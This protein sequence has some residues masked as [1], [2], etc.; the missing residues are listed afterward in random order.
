MDSQPVQNSQIQSNFIN[1]NV[2][3]NNLTTNFNSNDSFPNSFSSVRN[4]QFVN[5]SNLSGRNYIVLSSGNTSVTHCTDNSLSNHSN[6]DYSNS[7]TTYDGVANNSDEK[8]SAPDLSE[9][10]VIVP[11][12][13]THI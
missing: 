6:S 7:L 8:D 3:N 4:I 12:K 10:T 11:Q 1:H 9:P 13:R 5:Q 2:P